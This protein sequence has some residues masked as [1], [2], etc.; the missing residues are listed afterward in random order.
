MIDA[1]KS[2]ALVTAVAIA[3]VAFV[4]QFELV[5]GHADAVLLA[6]VCVALLRG[7][8]F[9]A[10]LG[11]WAGLLVDV[12]TFGTLGL[13]SLVLTLCGYW[14]GRIGEVTSNHEHQRARMLL[15]TLL[16]TVG[17]A[18]ATLVV[19]LFLGESASVGAVVARTLL[20]SLLLN[21]LLAVPAFWL[22]RKLLPPP[23]RREREVVA[24]V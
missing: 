9:G 17:A 22:V 14:A 23:A 15:T 7:P 2:F 11:F 16:L 6:L 3:Q 12:A 8:V 4:N 21:L 20:P 24:V 19:H 18:V 13:T 10:A 5:E 1:A